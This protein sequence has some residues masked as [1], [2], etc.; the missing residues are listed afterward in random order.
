MKSMPSWE[1]LPDGLDALPGGGSA[2]GL[3]GG[4][5]D[6]IRLN[7]AQAGDPGRDASRSSKIGRTS[8]ICSSRVDTSIVWLMVIPLQR[9]DDRPG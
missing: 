2:D 9:F 8:R 5:A 6:N 3:D 1:S 4:A 7:S